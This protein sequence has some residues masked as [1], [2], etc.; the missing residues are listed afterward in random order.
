MTASAEISG[1]E[2]AKAAAWDKIGGTFWAAGRTS[3]KPSTAELEL[4]AD[5]IGAGSRVIVVGASTK[6]LVETLI[7]RGAQVTVLDFSGRMCD[8]LRAALPADSCRVIQHDITGPAPAQLRST[9][10]YVLSDRLV[11]R[12]CGPEALAGIEGMADLLAPG[13]EVRASIKLGLYDM[14]RRMIAVG[15]ARGCTD[16]FFDAS[17][18]IIDFAA[19]GDV[20]VDALLPHGQ[21]STELL[22]DWYRGR[23]REQRFDHDD[24]VALFAAA[25]GVHAL[26]LAGSVEFPQAPETWLYR[27]VA[28]VRTRAEG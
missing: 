25:N 23:G 6:D 21:I 9:Q 28:R 27:A 17:N 11:N 22:L 16:Q 18:M 19:A 8:D 12:F 15:Q 14:D 5:G 24:L 1:N 7:V 4:F 26:D 3:A 20:L 10:R 2:N 13:G